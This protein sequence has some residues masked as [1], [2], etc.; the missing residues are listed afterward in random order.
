MQIKKGFS[1][2]IWSNKPI[3]RWCHVMSCGA[4]A[5]ARTGFC[6]REVCG[7]CCFL[8]LSRNCCFFRLSHPP[9]G[10]QTKNSKGSQNTQ[11]N[12]ARE[13]FGRRGIED[14]LRM[15]V[16]ALDT[17]DQ[18]NV[19]ILMYEFTELC[20]Y[21]NHNEFCWMDPND[22]ASLHATQNNGFVLSVSK[23]NS[24]WWWGARGCDSL[25]KATILH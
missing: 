19:L 14:V 7:K 22:P 3:W 17:Q 18:R 16:W 10:S 25:K 11:K 23:L 12:P 4:H 5:V 15:C 2:V 13:I 21:L 8:R 1:C 20:G 9:T 6:S 24:I